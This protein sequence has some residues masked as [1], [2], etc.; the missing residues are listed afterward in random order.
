[1]NLRIAEF[2]SHDPG[3]SFLIY[4]ATILVTA[5]ILKHII[6]YSM[7][8]IV[9]ADNIALR[10]PTRQSSTCYKGVSSRAVD[11]NTDTKYR[12]GNESGSC[13]YTCLETNMWWMVDF[14]QTA[15]VQ[16]INITN[17]GKQRRED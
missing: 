2:T 8:N 1:M 4:P 17:R 3:Y 16:S 12:F 9:T 11:G 6:Y 14:G 7:I 13:T 10:K 15:L 5:I